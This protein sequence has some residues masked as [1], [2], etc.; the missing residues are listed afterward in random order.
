MKIPQ[1]DMMIIT[2][3][4]KNARESL[5]TMARKTGIPIS[6]IFDKMKLHNGRIIRKHTCLLNFDEL[7]YATRAKVTVK[8]DRDSREELMSYL[9]SHSNVNSLYKIN[10]GYDFMFELIFKNIKELE[11]FMENLEE[12]YAITDRN[13]YYVIDDIKREEFMADN[14]IGTP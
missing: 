3:L 1:K 7:G 5:T 13:V 6:T 8:V 2:Q 14:H 4:R 10:S 12:N 9:N 11:E